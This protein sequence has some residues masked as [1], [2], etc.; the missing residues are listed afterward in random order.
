MAVPSS[1]TV[2]GPNQG[3]PSGPERTANNRQPFH[4]WALRCTTTNGTSV[5]TPEI[6]DT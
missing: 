4:Y 5:T 1:E 6:P 2:V 3:S